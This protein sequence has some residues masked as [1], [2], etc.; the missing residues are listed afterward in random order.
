M[1]KEG[2]KVRWKWGNGTAEGVVQSTFSK[3]V[4]RTIK[5]SE[6]TRDG[7]EGN[8]ALYIKQEDGDAVLKLESEVER[9]D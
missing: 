2:T 5:G 3:K 7:E 8:K 1:I 6:I 4:T 9:A